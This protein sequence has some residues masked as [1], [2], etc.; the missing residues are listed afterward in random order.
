MI[1][2]YSRV[3]GVISITDVVDAVRGK[4]NQLQQQSLT[5]EQH[6]FVT[7]FLRLLD[8]L[9]RQR[10]NV[11]N[12]YRVSENFRKE[13]ID[14]VV[15]TP[16]R[17]LSPESLQ[18]VNET[19]NEFSVQEKVSF[20]PF[21]DRIKYAAYLAFQFG[22]VLDLAD[23]PLD[24]QYYCCTIN[25][26]TVRNR[27]HAV[28]KQAR[29]VNKFDPNMGKL[30]M[31]MAMLPIISY[32]GDPEVGHQRELEGL[33]L[34]LNGTDLRKGFTSEYNQFTQH[35]IV[36]AVLA[37]PLDQSI[38][39]R[40]EDALN[41]YLEVVTEMI[42]VEIY[43]NDSNQFGQTAKNAVGNAVDSV[44]GVFDKQ[45]ALRDRFLNKMGF[46]TGEVGKPGTSTTAGFAPGFS[47]QNA[48]GYSYANQT[49]GFGNAQQGQSNQFGNAQQGQ[50]QRQSQYNQGQQNPWAK[51]TRNG[52]VFQNP[53]AQPE[54]RGQFSQGY[55]SQQQHMGFPN[56]ASMV[57]YMNLLLELSLSGSRI[58]LKDSF[59]GIEFGLECLGVTK[60]KLT[61]EVLISQRE[62]NARM[63]ENGPEGRMFEIRSASKKQS[64]LVVDA[65]SFVQLNKRCGFS[66]DYWDNLCLFNEKRDETTVRK[67]AKDAGFNVFDSRFVS[68]EKDSTA[69]LNEREK[70]IK[71]MQKNATASQ[72]PSD[73]G[74]EQHPTMAGTV[75]QKINPYSKKKS[76]VSEDNIAAETSVFQESEDNHERVIQFPNGIPEEPDD[77]DD[78]NL[79]DKPVKD[80]TSKATAVFEG[81]ET[82][83]N[84]L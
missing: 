38:L 30:F 19:L 32:S 62:F 51:Q 50:K 83:V 10:V 40:E 53:Y 4:L 14:W 11:L 57:A 67:V 34:N 82:P 84:P 42:N 16:L 8:L 43:R 80:Y 73:W 78:M 45:R 77:S 39:L 63:S 56:D 54:P 23:I 64:T 76:T 65:L 68:N 18:F 58:I 5:P 9:V 35:P 25:P 69:R 41:Q 3:M 66:Y 22:S 7:R 61:P 13:V 52:S 72:T 44:V 27:C 12:R 79:R 31:I 59:T 28:W 15:P 70:R 29:R 74:F 75:V 55:S 17:S 47:G 2:Q 71:E 81:E 24:K 48:R 60:D 21:R 20:L 1:H 26:E 37:N 6:A 46:Q 36:A 33:N 49:N